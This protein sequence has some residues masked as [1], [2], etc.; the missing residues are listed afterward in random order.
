MVV[1]LSKIFVINVIS[2]NHTDITCFI[3]NIRAIKFTFTIIT[4]CFMWKSWQQVCTYIF[5]TFN[6]FYLTVVTLVYCLV[7]NFLF[8][9]NESN[10]Y[11]G[12]FQSVLIMNSE[13]CKYWFSFLRA[14]KTPKAYFSIVGQSIWDVVSF[15]I[16]IENIRHSLNLD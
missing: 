12:G 9:M 10:I 7:L 15:G 14:Q 2:I 11:L 13:S 6:I 8:C 4:L 3:S 1:I 16:Q 5:L